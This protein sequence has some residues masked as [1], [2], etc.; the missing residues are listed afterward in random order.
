M[1]NL[2]L[3]EKYLNAN[4]HRLLGGWRDILDDIRALCRALAA[5]PDVCQCGNGASHLQGRCPCCH[6]IAVERVPKCT[7]CDDQLGS[8]RPAIDTLTVDSSRFFPTLRDLV[9]HA[10]PTAAASEYGV[11]IHIAGVVRMFGQ[12]LVAADAFKAECRLS[13]LNT[14]KESARALLQEAERLERAL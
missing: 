7:D 14:V 13:H 6:S 2:K 4:Q 8:L 1:N 11:E 12:L 10:I 5:L 9:A 3:P